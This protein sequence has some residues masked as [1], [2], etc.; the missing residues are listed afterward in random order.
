[1]SGSFRSGRARVK[2]NCMPIR[3]KVSTARNDVPAESQP[4]GPAEKFA[5][6]PARSIAGPVDD[7]KLDF[8]CASTVTGAW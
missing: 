4:R 8:G 5:K 1:M 6:S 7:N 3:A 2:V